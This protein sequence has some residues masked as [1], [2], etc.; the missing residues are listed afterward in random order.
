METCGECPRFEKCDEICLSVKKLIPAVEDGRNSDREVLMAPADLA[1]AADL[2]SLSDWSGARTRTSCPR[3][4]LV[5]LSDSEKRALMLIAEGLSYADAA[6]ALGVSR[7]T[8]QSYVA[9]ARVKLAVQSRHIVRT[10]K[11]GEIKSTTGGLRDD[12]KG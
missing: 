3:V 1:I 6:A 5:A 8:V 11:S 9:R 2:H 10:R 12:H 4:D 7:S